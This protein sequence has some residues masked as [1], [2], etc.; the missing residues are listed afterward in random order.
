MMKKNFLKLLAYILITFFIGS[1]FM[2]FGIDTNLYNNINKPFNIPRIIFPIV[3]GIL[4]FL[5]GY[6]AYIIENSNNK[7]KDKALSLYFKQLLFNSLWTL[8]F[9]GLNKCLLSFLWI[10]LL[11]I[12][13][14]LM[15]NKFYKI[16]KNAALINIPYLLWLL[17][18][19]YL[20]LSIYFLN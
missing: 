4:Y 7:D 11:I 13:V 12:L 10:I 16:N 5:M 6:S 1:F 2:I 15:I 18:A 8:I 19:S 9:F 3:W 17:F 14:V 20:N